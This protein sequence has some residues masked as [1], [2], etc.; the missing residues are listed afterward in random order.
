M[1]HQKEGGDTRQFDE[2]DRLS[3]GLP[4]SDDRDGPWRQ[5]LRNVGTLAKIAMTSLS[6][7]GYVT[8]HALATPMMAG[9][10]NYLG[11]VVDTLQ[12]Y[13]GS[14]AQMLARGVFSE[15]PSIWKEGW[16]VTPVIENLSTFAYKALGMQKVEEFNYVISG[17]AMARFADQLNQSGMTSWDMATVKRLRLN[18]SEIEEINKHQMSEFTKNKIIQNGVKFVPRFTL[19]SAMHRGVL[20]SKSVVKRTL[21]GFQTYTT[22]MGRI[23]FSLADEVGDAIKSKDPVRMIAAAKNT[24]VLL[25]GV[26]GVGLTAQVLRSVIHGTIAKQEPDEDM[27]KRV[28]MA[29]LEAGLLGP[30]QRMIDA[31]MFSGGDGGKLV[32]DLVPQVTV[33]VNMFQALL[34][35]GEYGRYPLGK[36]LMLQ[37]R[38]TT[39]LAKA[40]RQ[41]AENVAFPQRQDYD[42]AR[43]EVRKFKEQQTK[44]IG[45]KV[46]EDSSN[47]PLNP[48]V[49]YYCWR[50]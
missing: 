32:S 3:Q 49:H 25:A 5:G 10:Y 18:S 9:L 24:G 38:D 34:G 47:Q 42:Q 44:D 23:A 45:L 36:R 19:K 7:V 14:K 48:E 46:I 41:W 20:D 29:F 43:A 17:R 33:L 30:A 2:V 11:G 6:P 37:A 4:I 1:K 15:A 21:V 13:K 12:N 39:P 22:G 16:G 27:K 31:T 40:S 50:R 28:G 8:Q 35:Y 26:L